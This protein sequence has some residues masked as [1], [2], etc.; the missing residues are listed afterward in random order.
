MKVASLVPIALALACATACGDDSSTSDVVDAGLETSADASPFETKPECE[1]QAIVPMMGDRQMVISSI[2]IGSADDGLDLDNDGSPDNKMAAL[3]SLAED[4]IAAAF[5]DYS[6]LLPLEFFDANGAGDD[7]CIKFAVYQGEYRLDL[8]GDDLLSAGD[9]GDCNDHRAASS[10][11]TSEVAGNRIDDDCDGLADEAG[12]TPSTDAG[13][14]DGDGV[15]LAQGDCDDTLA[16]IHPGLTEVCGDGLDNNCDGVADWTV[17]ADPQHCSPFDEELDVLGVS[18]TSFD[19]TGRPTVTFTSGTVRLVDGVLRL[20]SGPSR[21]QLRMPLAAGLEVDLV[22]TAATIEA[23]MV[24]TPG[25]WTLQNGKLGGVLNA[26][27]TDQIRGL[28]VEIIDLKPEDSLADAIYTS[29]LGAIF[30]LQAGPADSPSAG[31]LRPDMD[32]DGDGLEGFCDTSPEDDVNTIGKCVD[33]DGTVVLDQNSTQCTEAVDSDG[34]LRFV[35][36]VSI[37]IKFDTVPALLPAMTP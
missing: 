31:C 3:G 7:S 26:H 29:V 19:A 13:D 8:D 34:N 22:I 23:D 15:S 11:T 10:R 35:D 17:G 16:S 6:L 2:S 9:L 37:L 14:E 21:F 4:S 1:G 28:E 20:Q 36:G 25:G 33:G 5:A 27:T 32:V 12:D 18:S 24:M 30:A